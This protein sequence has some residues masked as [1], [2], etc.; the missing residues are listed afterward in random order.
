[1]VSYDR[2]KRR[3]KEER[4]KEGDCIGETNEFYNVFTFHRLH[5]KF[6]SFVDKYTY[7]ILPYR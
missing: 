4:K 6:K 1:M 3:R 7:I 5:R 2:I